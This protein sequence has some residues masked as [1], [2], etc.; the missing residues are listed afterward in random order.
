MSKDTSKEDKKYE[1]DHNYDGIREYNYP[2]PTWWQ[3]IFFGSIIWAVGYFMYYYVFDGETLRHSLDRQLV[4]IDR[5]NL[6]SA[7]AGPSEDELM[8]LV[9]DP[10]VVGLGKVTFLGKCSSCHGEHGQGIIGPNLTDNYWLHGKGLAADIFKTVEGGVADKGMPPW[11][12]IL[13]P[14]E[15]KN[16]VAYVKSIRGTHPSNPKAPQGEEVKP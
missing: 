7:G 8:K 6:K 14:T 2:A 11:G 10:A 12:P 5:E 3:V 4:E 13:S 15:L 16:V 1:M 9:A